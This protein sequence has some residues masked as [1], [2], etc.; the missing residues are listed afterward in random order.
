MSNGDLQQYSEAFHADVASNAHAMDMLREQSFVEK[1]GEILVDYGELGSCEP[2]YFEARGMKVDAYDFDDEYINMTLVISCWLD[3]SDPSQARVTNT[4]IDRH[5]KRGRS[6]LEQALTGRL[7]DRID[8]SSPAHDLAALIYE[9]RDSLLSVKL[10]LVTDGVAE[11]RQADT[12]VRDGLEIRSVVWDIS[13]ACSFERTGE[14]EQIAINFQKD[15]GGAIPCVRRP[16]PGQQ[17]ET[18]LAFISGNVLADLYATWKIRLLERNVRVFLSQRPQVNQGMRDTIREEPELFCAYNNGITVYAQSVELTNLAN[19]ALGIGHVTDFQIVNGGQTT[20][21]LYHTREKLKCDLDGI[22][23]QMKL[24]VIND[25]LHPA[26]VPS[27]QRLSDILVPKIG[28]FSNTQNRIQ[29]ADLLANDP[30]HPELQMISMNTLAPDPTGGSVQTYWFYEKSRGSYEE[31]RRLD[32]KTPAQQRKFDQKYPRSQRFDKSKFGKA[33]N[34]Y[35]K[36]P[37]IVCLGAMKNF[38]QFNAWLQDQKNEDWHAFFRKTIALVIM[39]NET[40]RIVRRQQYGGY[41]HAIATYTLAWLHHLTDLRIDLERIW[42]RQVLDDPLLEAIERLSEIVNEHVR[43]TNLNVTEWCKKEEC[44][45]KLILKRA[46][47]YPDLSA[48]YLSGRNHTHYDAASSSEIANIMFCKQKGAEAWFGLSKWLKEH[49][50]MQ[51]KQ[52]SQCFNMGRT[53][54]NNNKEPSAVLSAACRTIW[55]KA[56][57]GYGWDAEP[58]NK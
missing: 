44:W 10:I 36:R 47:E 13:R 34:S 14:R 52:R 18:Y 26:N 54:K 15:Y 58:P 27:D 16:S 55:Q 38:A 12:D 28:R 43:D 29:M 32:A 46:P 5:M 53:L 7:A 6:F 33:W 37:H 25:D 17:Y 3:Q 41:N 1:I 8:I 19:G 21:S 22:A 2:C 39:W 11:Q 56:A 35:R 24:M 23:V 20:A 31:K 49:D 45:D 9:C 51:G 4:E 48:T 57:E 42:S 50:F 40:E 30:P